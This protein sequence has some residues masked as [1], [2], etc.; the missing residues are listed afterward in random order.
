MTRFGGFLLPVTKPTFHRSVQ[1]EYGQAAIDTQPDHLLTV[2][3][4]SDMNSFRLAILH[5]PFPP[6]T[7]PRSHA[8]ECLGDSGL[9]LSSIEYDVQARCKT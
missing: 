7:T 4:I 2:C 8:G 5:P 9:G 6:S 1:N 3:R